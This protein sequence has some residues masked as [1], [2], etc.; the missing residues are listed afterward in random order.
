[1]QN[2][3]KNPPVKWERVGD[4]PCYRCGVDGHWYKKCHASANVAA[5]YKRYRESKEQESHFMNEEGNDADVSLTIAD[6]SGKDFA[7][8][9]DALD[10]D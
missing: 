6:F 3:P 2:A 5:S 10:F 7:R 4:E 9:M 1:M 8:S